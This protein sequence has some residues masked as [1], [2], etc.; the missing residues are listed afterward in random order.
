[1]RHIG[2]DGCKAGWIAVSKDGDELTYRIAN[3]VCELLSAFPIAERVLID[4]P[5]GLPWRDEPIRPCDRLARSIL[6]DRRSSVFPVPCRTAVR[7]EALGVARELNR[8]ELGRS[9]SEQSWGICRKIREVD[10]LLLGKPGPGA[11]VPEVHPEICFWALAGR[12]PMKHNKGQEFLLCPETDQLAPSVALAYDSPLTNKEALL[13][14]RRFL[15]SLSWVER[16]PLRETFGIGTGGHPGKIGKGDSARL[17]NPRFRI[18][19]L[20]ETKDPKAQL[21]LALYR[22]AMNLNSEPFQLLGF[23]KIINALFKSG[24]DQKAWINKTLP[25]LDDH[26]VRG[27]LEELQKLHSDIGDY[28][29]DSGRCAVAHAFNEPLVD[30]DDPEDT[31]RL[32]ADLPVIK[33]LAEHL[34]EHEVG[35]KSAVTY[36]QEH[37]Y[38][39]EGFR[40][41]FGETIISQLKAKQTLQLRD[42]PL[43][44][45]LSIRIRDKERYQ[46]FECLHPTILS[47]KDGC[48]YLRCLSKDGVV[49]L[50]VGLN[51][52]AERIEF[53]PQGGV[54]IRDD[55]TPNAVR[56]GLD[57]LRFFREHI[58]NG[59][60]EIWDAQREVLLGRTDP[61]IP[62]NVDLGRT[63]RNLDLI[64]EK[65]VV[66][67]D[68]RSAPEEGACS[69]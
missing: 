11:E 26:R 47:T 68:V 49:A 55:G 19:Y 60:L 45:R 33:A 30:P 27:R 4:V 3:T 22:E 67:V 62:I 36:H 63:I 2:V 32:S 20:P 37:L 59:Q 7:A 8:G 41:L 46:A 53:D 12:L 61:L 5:I 28:L 14:I 69:I 64:Q 34:M 50:L 40:R 18:D 48:V 58:C 44:P 6:G 43:L 13:L 66:A 1:M 25:V 42:F 10:D 38:E 56:M 35:I 24:V 15:S 29:Y 9:L 16:G 31:Q 52:P 23:F 54:S 21:C 39:L 57:Q 51:F 17:I 65:L